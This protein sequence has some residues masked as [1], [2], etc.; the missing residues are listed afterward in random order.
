VTL[1]P[2][3]AWNL[4]HGK[5]SEEDLGARP[6]EKVGPAVMGMGMRGQPGGLSG[7]RPEFHPESGAHQ[8]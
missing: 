4:S 2:E 6:E 7:T 8:P 5:R 3:G 1:A